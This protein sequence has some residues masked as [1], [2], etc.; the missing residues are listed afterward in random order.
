MI[1]GFVAVAGVA[2]AGMIVVMVGR[3]FDRRCPYCRRVFDNRNEMY[4]HLQ[5]KHHG[6]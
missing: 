2:V 6:A 3:W 5:R 4:W 1:P